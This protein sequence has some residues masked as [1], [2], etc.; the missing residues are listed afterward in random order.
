MISVNST[1]QSHMPHLITGS[2]TSSGGGGGGLAGR[3][4]GRGSV[5]RCRAR[6][7]DKTEALSHERTDSLCSSRAVRGDVRRLRHTATFIIRH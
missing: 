5:G 3:R 6:P 4:D 2:T 7:F 1:W